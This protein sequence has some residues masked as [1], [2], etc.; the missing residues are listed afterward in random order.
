VRRS[1]VRGCAAPGSMSGSTRANCAAV[2]VVEKRIADP[3]APAMFIFLREPQQAFGT[4]EHLNSGI[5][6]AFMVFL[7]MPSDW[8]RYARQHVSFQEFARQ[9]GMLEYWRKA[10]WPDLCRPAPARG[11]DAFTCK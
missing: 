6:D 8:S 5:A 3:L 11:P 9:M 1:F 2:A 4:F 10:G 7:W